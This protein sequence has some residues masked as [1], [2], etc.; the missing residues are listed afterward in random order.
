MK[1]IEDWLG[2]TVVHYRWLVIV[3]CLAMAGLAAAGMTKLGFV[4][5]SRMFFSDDNPQLQA[6]EVLENTYTKYDNIIFVL[7]P[8]T[9]TVF[10][11]DTLNAVYELTAEAWK[12]PYSSRVDSLTN[13]QH[14]R[15][16]GDDLIVEDL[17]L[18]PSGLTLDDLKRIKEIALHEPL[19]IDHVVAADGRVTGINVNTI[20]PGKNHNEATEMAEYGRNLASEIE[21]RHPGLKIYL[22]GGVMVDHA[23]GEASKR[24]LSTLIPCMFGVLLL[25]MVVALRSVVGTAATFMVI[26]LSMCTGLGLAGWFGFELSPASANAPVIILTLAVADSIHILVTM[27]QQMRAGLTKHA[28]IGESLRVN[29]QPV[30]VTSLTTSIGF[31]SMNFSDAPPFRDLGNI[32]S[33]GIGAAFIYSVFLLPALMGVL[34]V[35]VKAASGRPNRYGRLAD[36]IISNRSKVFWAMLIV[37]V[38]FTS[39]VFR[40][41]LDDT[42]VEY[43]DHSYDFRVASDFSEENLVGLNIIDFDLS[44]GEE[45]GVNNPEYQQTVED[46]ANWFRTQD[47]VRYVYAI[48]DIYKKLNKSMH[49]DQGEWYKLPA[50]RELAAQYLLLYEMSLPFG[51]D[52]NDRINV[53]KSASR[54]TVN[55][56]QVSSK[57]LR[58]L[59]VRGRAWLQENAPASMFTHGSG[60]SMV[61][62]HISE[63]NINS[64]LSASV[65]ALALI[66]LILVLV[67]RDVKL[68]LLSLLPNLFPAF[69][70]FGFWGYA[71]GEVGLSVSVMIAMTLGIVVDD[72]VHFLSKYQRARRE[73]G[74]QS[75]EAVRYAFKTV[76][77]AIM[78][79][80]IILTVGFS[81]LSLSGFQINSHMGSM[82]AITIVFAFMLDFFFLPTLLMKLEEKS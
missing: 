54:L 68:G 41:N 2:H 25:V 10:T 21:Q 34:P 69:M 15:A 62:A 53:D 61:F 28:A 75:K 36:F 67:L 63:R 19:L 79:T 66:S 18:D 33:M 16:E 76:G 40:I 37:V 59:E 30:L 52:L 22:T 78:V 12:I 50:E 39:G 45:G 77:S 44:S 82:T 65:L 6:L 80:S 70:A 23:F 1:R 57:E 32:V 5:D 64:M 13:Y 31:L 42:F 81:V 8:A 74:L 35:R 7:K 49:G 3:C 47:K 20:K 24:D 26:G 11:K 58:A 43:F 48:T 72:T 56:A 46:F 55:L 60:L 38:V 51:L 4:N 17:V 9:D 14:T 29:F 27:F 71:V 73:H